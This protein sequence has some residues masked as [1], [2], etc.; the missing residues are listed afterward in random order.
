MTGRPWDGQGVAVWG[1]L[2]GTRDFT[3]GPA[4]YHVQTPRSGT[5][6]S[7]TACPTRFSWAALLLCGP[8]QA[9]SET[10]FPGSEMQ[11]VMLST[12]GQ[13]GH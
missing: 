9:R 6:V 4:S 1:R 10:Q 5:P 3:L 11:A 2:L 12:E 13:H 7:H 8:G